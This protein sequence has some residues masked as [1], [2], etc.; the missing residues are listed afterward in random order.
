MVLS[1]KIGHGAKARNADFFSRAAA[2]IANIGTNKQRLGK[3]RRH[4]RDLDDIAAVQ[5]R[6]RNRAHVL[7]YGLLR[8]AAKR[9][10]APRQYGG[11]G[12]A[13]VHV[14]ITTRFMSGRRSQAQAFLRAY[15]RAVHYMH[16]NPEGF[17]KIITR[18]S[19]IADPGMLK[20]TVQYAYEFVEK[21]PLVERAAFQNTVDEIAE[22]RPEAK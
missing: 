3:V 2:Q 17:K 12:I 18:Y 5:W 20:G 21:I 8:C 15:S 13:F 6:Y 10:E 4:R 1:A 16:T 22:R 9:C 14:G 11:G 19:K 7:S